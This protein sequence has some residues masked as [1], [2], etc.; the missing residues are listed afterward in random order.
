MSQIDTLLNQAIWL[1]HG[2]QGH[3]SVEY[4]SRID[5]EDTAWYF[6]LKNIPGVYELKLMCIDQDKEKEKSKFALKYY[7]H[8]EEA[9]FEGFS[10]EEKVVR[11]GLLFD[12]STIDIRE[13]EH[14]VCPC[15]GGKHIER[16][17]K[18]ARINFT[19]Q[20]FKSQHKEIAQ[21]IKQKD[22]L[23]KACNG[24][25]TKGIPKLLKR[26]ILHHSLFLIGEIQFE[27]QNELL[28]SLQLVTQTRL[29]QYEDNGLFIRDQDGKEIEVVAQG[30]INRSVA[31]LKLCQPFYDFMVE[32][33]F[34]IL[35]IKAISKVVNKDIGTVI[36]KCNE[37]QG[38]EIVDAEV[39]K[40]ELLTIF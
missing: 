20:H 4:L 3:N 27:L 33:M 7:P 2:D 37:T 22:I 26:N 23:D 19:Q 15:C 14:E 13:E 10:I 12:N 35:S 38:Y 9:E 18:L 39:N 24:G 36:H 32:E 31:G 29:V 34:G 40:V 6:W 1:L 16:K 25:R 21:V 8:T 28:K 11:L 17:P 30:Q 5:G